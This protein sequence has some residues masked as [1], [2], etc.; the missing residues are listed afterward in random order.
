MAYAEACRSGRRYGAG[1]QSGEPS[2]FF[3]RVTGLGPVP[4]TPT[5]KTSGRLESFVLID[6]LVVAKTM[7]EPSGGKRSILEQTDPPPKMR[8]LPQ[9]GAIGPDGVE[10]ALVR[11]V[12][13][14]GEAPDENESPVG[15][16]V[17][18]VTAPEAPRSHAPH[19]CAVEVGDVRR[20]SVLGLGLDVLVLEDEP[21]SVR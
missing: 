6:P 15:R 3:E 16:P 13:T 1:P 12:G 8:Q 11:E 21:L 4:S 18:M 2:Q 14:V 19:A 10:V 5:V 7:A 17:R 20:M 9:T